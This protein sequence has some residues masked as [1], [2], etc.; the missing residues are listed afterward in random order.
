MQPV[1]VCDCYNYA[2]KLGQ[3]VGQA[4]AEAIAKSYGGGACKQQS[5]SSATA[6]AADSAGK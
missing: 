2:L 1:V 6:V 3:G 5:G 4:V